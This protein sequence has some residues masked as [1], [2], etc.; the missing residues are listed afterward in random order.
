MTIYDS[1]SRYHSR[2]SS[3]FDWAYRLDYALKNMSDEYLKNMDLGSCSTILSTG[4]EITKSQ[5]LILLKKNIICLN[6]SGKIYPGEFI[7]NR[8][9]RYIMDYL[10]LHS[11]GNLPD[12]WNKDFGA[13][14]TKFYSYDVW[15]VVHLGYSLGHGS[16][17]AQSDHPKIM[18]NNDE[19]YLEPLSR[20]IIDVLPD[21]IIRGYIPMKYLKSGLDSKYCLWS[22]EEKKEVSRVYDYFLRLQ[23]NISDEYLPDI[24]FIFESEQ[25]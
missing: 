17:S 20:M 12:D 23:R 13:E 8:P 16:I 11:L 2:I 15:H 6:Y 3:M 4:Y 25:N 5:F 7:K 1:I 14:L 24:C 9:A 22:E 21:K 10:H 19:L 18:I